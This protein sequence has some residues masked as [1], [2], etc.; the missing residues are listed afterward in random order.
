MVTLKGLTLF[1]LRSGESLAYS[2]EGYVDLNHVKDISLNDE[3]QSYQESV[4]V[5]IQRSAQGVFEPKTLKIVYGSSLAENRNV[6]FLCPPN[7]GEMWQKVLPSLV[8]GVKEEDTRMIWLK[9]QYLFL[10]FQDD[11]CMGPLAA[12]AI[13]VERKKR[14][15]IHETDPQ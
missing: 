1:F 8:K 12:D 15:L 6:T 11:L 9:D 10:Y 13:K 14:F 2:D 4:R 3:W 7:L 5:A